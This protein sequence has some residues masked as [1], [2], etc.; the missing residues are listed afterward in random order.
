MPQALNASTTTRDGTLHQIDEALDYRVK[1][2]KVNRMNP[3]LNTRFWTMKDVDRSKE[4]MFTIQKCLKTRRIFHNLESF[5]GGQGRECDLNMK[6]DKKKCDLLDSS[7]GS[8]IC[9]KLFRTSM[10]ILRESKCGVDK[11][12]L[13]AARD[14]QKSYAKNR[15]KPLEFKVGDRVLL[16]VS[17]WKGMICFGKKGKLAPRYVGPL[18]ILERIGPVAYRLRLPEELS[19]VHDTFHVSN[20]KKCLADDNLHVPLDE[21]K[22]DKTLHFVE[23][24]VEIMDREVKSLKRTKISLV[25]VRW[26]TKHG[27]EFIWESEDK[28]LSIISYLLIVLLNQLVKSQDEISLRKGYCDTRDLNRRHCIVMISI[29]VTPRVSALAGCDNDHEKHACILE[30]PEAE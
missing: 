5:V 14:H 25:K 2:F 4:L 21:I 19:S 27:P 29:L 23:E 16:K 11:E 9:A 20:L 3:G 15:R 30:A 17:P 22:I 8:P 12:N 28:S 1:E 7:V 26:N 18:E 10:H 24:P 6:C 13:K